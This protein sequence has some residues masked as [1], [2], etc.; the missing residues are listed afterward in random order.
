[1]KIIWSRM[2]TA[3]ESNFFPKGN[4][5]LFERFVAANGIVGWNDFIDKPEMV[6]YSLHKRRGHMKST[7]QC[8]VHFEH[9][10]MYLLPNYDRVYVCHPYLG[11]EV[12]EY[13]DLLEQWA[14]DNGLVAKVYDPTFDWYYHSDDPND[15]CATSLVIVHLPGV[16]VL[17]P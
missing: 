10:R 13:R 7:D 14:K 3:D 9:G 12:E 11:D 5:E 1:M 4:P 15:F 8:K 6:A 16:K 17:A 2:T